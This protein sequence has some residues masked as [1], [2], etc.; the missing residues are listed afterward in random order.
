MKYLIFC[1]VVARQIVVMMLVSK[2]MFLK[3]TYLHKTD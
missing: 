3:K 2:A 1:E